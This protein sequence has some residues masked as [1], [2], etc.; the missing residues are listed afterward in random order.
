MDSNEWIKIRKILIK[1]DKGLTSLLKKFPQLSFA[2]DLLRS[3]YHSLVRAIAHQQ[4]HVKAAETILN[5][6]QQLGSSK[7]N[8]PTP[9]EVAELTVEVMRDC[10][11]SQSKIKSIKS[12]AE[13]ALKGHLPNATKIKKMSNEE[14]IEHLT[15]IFGVGKWT[16]EMLLIFQLG[17]LDVWPV[18]D[19][20]VRRGYQLWKKLKT[21][22]TSKQIK[23]AGDRWAP[24]QSIVALMLWRVADESKIKSKSKLKETKSHAKTKK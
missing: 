6:F 9:E 5:R 18:D 1:S 21:L 8:L 16:V 12:I 2:P 14:I 17:R 4:L 15:P 20:G 24:Y 19:F 10:G 13:H 11:F 3:P 23:N 7:N 22:P